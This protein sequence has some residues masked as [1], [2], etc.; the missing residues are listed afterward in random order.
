METFPGGG[1]KER[2]QK[3]WKGIKTKNILDGRKD[4][5]TENSIPPSPFGEQGYN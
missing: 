1:C 2:S 5:Q 4:G 3:D